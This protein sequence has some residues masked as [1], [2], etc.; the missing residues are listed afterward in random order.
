LLHHDLLQLKLITYFTQFQIII[1]CDG[2]LVDGAVC[3]R[4]L[5]WA[6]DRQGL[7]MAPEKDK[8]LWLSNVFY[9]F[10]AIS[11]PL[12]IQRSSFDFHVDKIGLLPYENRALGR[13]HMA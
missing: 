10:K 2:P 5:I 11:M 3:N 4:L 6:T 9:R 13:L 8:N 7:T 12:F 1:S